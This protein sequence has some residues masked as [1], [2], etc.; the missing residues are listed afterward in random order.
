MTFFLEYLKCLTLA[1]TGQIILKIIDKYILR[2]ILEAFIFGVVIFASVMLASEA[3]LD[4]IRQISK[5]GIPL[6]IAFL[7]VALKLPGIIVYTLPMA[8]LVSVILTYNRLNSNLE[9]TALKS[10]G[11]S[12][13]RIL[14]PAL[15]FGSSIALLTLFL[16]EIVVPKANYQA[17]NIMLW[18]VTQRNL[19]KS[20]ENFIYKQLSGKSKLERLFYIEK[21]KNN[22]MENVIVI[23]QSDPEATKIIKAK[24]ALSKRESWKFSNGKVYT[25]STDGDITN[26][27]SFQSITLDDP[28]KIDLKRKDHRSKEMNFFELAEVIQKEKASGKEVSKTLVIKWYQKITMPLTCIL[29]ALVGVPLA[30]SP[31][32]SRFNRGLGFSVIIIFIFYL[33]RALSMSLGEINILSPVLAAWLPNVVIL[34]VGLILL[35][36]KNYF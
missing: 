9:I 25:V 22:V 5:F 21:F 6:N 23:D 1:F 33:L 32:R 30:I 15:I 8:L 31:P 2:S 7:I 14:I 27:S 26:T 36:K 12:L 3:F 16:N 28:V 34:I 19:P 29:V 35:Q 18:A 11:V 13:Y 24:E 10:C 17:R 4:V 20:S